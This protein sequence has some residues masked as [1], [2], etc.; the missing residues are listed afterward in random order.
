MCKYVYFRYA[1]DVNKCIFIKIT[2]SYTE[3]ISEGT[4]GLRIEA[5]TNG[6]VNCY[7]RRQATQYGKMECNNIFSS[8]EY[9]HWTKL[10][11]W[12]GSHLIEKYARTYVNKLSNPFW[13][14]PKYNTSNL[15]WTNINPFYLLWNINMTYPYY[16]LSY[17]WHR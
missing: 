7:L 12:T 8:H 13:T 10:N 4:N 11:D 9:L 17:I 16:L 1:L 2:S 5:A 14:H 6:E 3:Q 15:W